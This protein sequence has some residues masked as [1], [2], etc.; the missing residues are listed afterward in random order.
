MLT[1]IATLP[2]TFEIPS[3]KFYLTYNNTQKTNRALG[4][5]IQNLMQGYK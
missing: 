3:S 4:K 5:E 1:L 2:T